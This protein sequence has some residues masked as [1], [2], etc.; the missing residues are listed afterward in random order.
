[1][2]TAKPIKDNY[3]VSDDFMHQHSKTL[4]LVFMGDQALFTARDADFGT[5]FE[6]N[7]LTAI[8]TA[9]AHPTDELVDDMMRE[10]TE[11]VQTAMTN[12]RN[13][14]MDTKPFVKKTFPDNPT[15]WDKFG[16][17]NYQNI[18]SNQEGL[19]RFFKLLHGTAT[20]YAVELIAK[21]Y[22]QAMID[23]I[24]TLR[25]ALETA[26]NEQEKFK[27]DIPVFTKQRTDKNNT[28]YGFSQRVCET[29]KL[30]FRDDYSKYQQYLLPASDEATPMILKGK[31]TQPV[32][33]P[34]GTPALPVQ[35]VSIN[36]MG[37]PALT[38]QSDSNGNYGF[39]SIPAGTYTF[40][41]NKPGY[42]PQSMPGVVITDIAHPVT[43]NVVMMPMP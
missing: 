25:A 32:V 10:K 21:N 19:T 23:E 24:E 31:V 35:G 2:S 4:R 40:N 26:N 5:P 43:L 1:M 33:G 13:K 18:D 38:T 36:I 12:C 15:M 42:M 41:F 9:E 11:A 29:G 37:L 34:A 16:F 7:W 27:L 3:T 30:I 17:N 28:V 14:W 22:T 39:G 20:Q 6:M 8:S